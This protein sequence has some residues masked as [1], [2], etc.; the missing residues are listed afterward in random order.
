MV[1]ASRAG[2]GWRPCVLEVE[3]CLAWPV[4]RYSPVSWQ[5]CISFIPRSGGQAHPVICED[6]D[7]SMSVKKGLLVSSHI[8]FVVIYNLFWK[9]H[10]FQS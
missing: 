4:A 3:K 7:S 8:V 5:F 10:G 6:Y 2:P 9:K 1:T